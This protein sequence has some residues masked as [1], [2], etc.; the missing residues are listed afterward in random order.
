MLPKPYKFRKKR[1]TRRP[2][3]QQSIE[4]EAKQEDLSGFVQGQEATDIEERFAVALYKNKLSFSFREH[5]FGPARNT[6]GAI[7]VD[8]MVF[9]GSW[10]PVQID[11]EFAHKSATQQDEDRAKD[12]ILNNYFSQSGVNNVIRIP[13]G[14]IYQHGILDEQ[15]D[16]D[17]LVEE[18]WG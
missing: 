5:Y 3:P 9:D 2:R 8:F 17:R 18:T 12:A 15:D 7:E 16:V 4:R 14:D 10:W 1:K 11:G 13:D 6:P